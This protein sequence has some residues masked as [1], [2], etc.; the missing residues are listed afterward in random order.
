VE[1]VSKAFDAHH[2]R[3]D[4]NQIA[5]ET[6]TLVLDKGSAALAHPVALEEAGVGW[7]R[8]ALAIKG[9]RSCAV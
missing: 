2:R 5:R 4:Q 3:L 1:E 9:R 8:L 6:V 7:S